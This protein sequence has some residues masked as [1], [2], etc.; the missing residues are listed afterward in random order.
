MQTYRSSKELLS[1]MNPTGQRM[2]R[3][4][5]PYRYTWP[6]ASGTPGLLMQAAEA[7]GLTADRINE[8]GFLRR[9]GQIQ[10]IGVESALY[11]FISEIDKWVR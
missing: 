6:F 10:L 5:L 3:V 7:K 9:N 2:G 11:S 8:T 1:A 4:L